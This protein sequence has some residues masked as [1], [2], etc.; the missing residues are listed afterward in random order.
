MLQLKRV[1]DDMGKMREF[2]STTS[3]RVERNKKPFRHFVLAPVL[4]N[5]EATQ[6]LKLLSELKWQQNKGPFFSFYIP[7][8]SSCPRDLY[9][10]LDAR[11]SF[12]EMSELMAEI[13][14]V[15]LCEKPII[16][17]HKVQGRG[18]D[19]LGRGDLPVVARS[20]QHRR[21]RDA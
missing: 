18:A 10:Y 14:S 5:E 19:E 21:A 6:V 3:L 13:L 15:H 17:A 11:K 1:T 16:D 12:A 2:Y 7:V 4:D 20:G 9:D 8:G